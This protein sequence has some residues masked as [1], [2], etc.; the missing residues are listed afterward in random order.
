MTTVSS[1]A[2]DRG[3]RL[4]IAAIA[5]GGL[6]LALA[7]CARDVDTATTTAA[8]S[9]DY[10]VTHPISLQEQIATLDV[11]VTIDSAR[12]TEGEK[13]NILFFAQ[14]YLASGTA[15]VAV[16]APS[17]SPNQ[18]AAR[19][20]AGQVEDTLRTAGVPSRA[21][22]SRVYRADP[23]DRV[24]P[25]RLAYN[26][27]V[28]ATDP[29]G[30]WPDLVTDT[31]QNRHY[32]SYGCAGQQNL[33]AMVANPLDLLYPRGMTP[34]DATRRATVLGKYRLGQSVSS[35]HSGENG[36]TVATG[37]GQ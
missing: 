8:L 23:H 29:C 7:G 12:L 6:A 10:R 31:K 21:I 11:P 4:G 15:I 37:V 18:A 35:D 30:P 2:S 14:S 5:A 33:A 13:S 25:V 27:V 22:A 32:E 36:G 24:A 26:R 16:V 19:N 17:G 34:P 9:D 28:A 3:R 1:L 20:I